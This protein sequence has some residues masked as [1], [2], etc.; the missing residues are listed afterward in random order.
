MDQYLRKKHFYMIIQQALKVMTVQDRNNIFTW[1]L[2][3]ILID[4]LDC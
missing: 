4:F 3:S 2:C 1:V